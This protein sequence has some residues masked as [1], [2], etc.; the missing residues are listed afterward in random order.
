MIAFKV[1]GLAFCD[2]DETVRKAYL[3]SIKKY[4]PEHFPEEYKV[5]RKAYELIETHQKRLEYFLF[6]H[7]QDISLEDYKTLCLTI[8]KT[9]TADKWNNLCQHYLKSKSKTESGN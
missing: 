4:P 9:I 7:E 5:V 6:G 1:L 8:D 2:D 3:E